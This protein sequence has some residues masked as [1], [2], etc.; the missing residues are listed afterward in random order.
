MTLQ[1]LT[2]QIVGLDEQIKAGSEALT[3]AELKKVLQSFNDLFK[4]IIEADLFN[5]YPDIIPQWNEILESALSSAWASRIAENLKDEVFYDFGLYLRDQAGQHREVTEKLIHNYLDLFRRSSFLQKIENIK[6]WE[7][8]VYEL[9]LKSNFNVNALFRQ[10]VRDYS[11]K[12]LFRLLSPS[13][14]RDYNWIQIKDLVER[15]AYGLAR[16]A[17][18]GGKKP[19]KIAFLME[20]SL[21][22]AVADLACLTSGL[23]NIMMPANSVPQQIEFILKQT[24]VRIIL[25]FNDKQLAKI[26]AIKKNLPYLK[27]VVLVRGSSIEEWVITLDEMLNTGIDFPEKTLHNMQQSVQMDDLATIMYTSGT[28]GE[29]KG[30]MFSYMN[31]VYKRFCRAMALPKISDK[32]RY[33]AYLPLFHT[34]GRY[35]ELMGA[36]FWGAE[37]AFMENPALATMIDN[38]KRVKPTIFISIPKKWQQLYEYVSSR[39]DIELAEDAAIKKEVKKATGG[40]LKWGLSAAGYL[41]PDI[42]K[43]FQRYGI[44]LMSGFGMTEATGGITMTYPG[45]YV[46][47]SLGRPLP[48]IE[49]KLSDEGEMMIRGP[50]V[51]MGYYGV[52][53]QKMV[54]VDGWLPTGDI[55]RRDKNGYYEIIDR[56][57]EI[58]KNIK[59][60]TIAPQRIENMFRDFEYVEQVF[61]VGDHQPF[62]TVLIYPAYDAGPMLKKMNEEERQNYFSSLVVTVNKFLAPFE[63]IVDFRIIDRPF[64]AEKGELTPKNTYKRRVIEK[65]FADIIDNMYTKPHVS[66]YYD[67]ME[68][69]IPNW[70]LREKG[71]LIN[72]LSFNRNGL[73]IAKYEQK[74]MLKAT[75]KDNNQYRIGNYYYFIDK[76]YI[77]FQVILANPYYWLGNQELMDFAGKAIFQ[78]FRVDEPDEKIR[79]ASIVKAERVKKADLEELHK[80]VEGDEHSL[81][82]LNLAVRFLQSPKED[83]ALIGVNYLEK[84]LSDDNFP[85]K[86]LGMEILAQPGYNRKLPVRRALFRLAHKIADEAQFERYLSVY[87][88]QSAD[89]LNDELI[90]AIGRS[91]RGEELVNCVHSVLKREL[92]RISKKTALEK[93][94]IPSLLNM[95]AAYGVH[96]P[97]KYKRVRQLLVRYQL[98]KDYRGLSKTASEARYKLLNGFREWLGPNQAVSVDVETGQEYRWQDVVIFDERIP[99]A[100]RT[101]ILAALSNTS[102][103]REAIFLFSGGNMV[104]LYDI[105]LAGVWI[106]IIDDE[107][108]KTVYRLSVQTRFQGAYDIALNLSRKPPSQEILDEINWLIHSG[109]PAKGLRLLEDFG[110]YWREYNLW[111]EEYIPGDK[112][113]KVLQRTLRRNTEEARQRIYHL[114]PFFIWTAVSAHVSFWKRAGYKLELQDKSI[115]NMVIAPHDYQTGL[116]IISIASRVPSKGLTELLI[117]FYHQ[118]ILETEQQYPFL[119]RNG[120]CNNMF[121]G[122]LDSEGEE[123]GVALLHKVVRELNGLSDEVSSRMRRHLQIFLGRIQ[124]YGF[125]PKK[126]YFA[127]KRFHRWFSINTEASLS[128]QARTLNELYDTYQLQELEKKHPETR[129]RFYLDT[130][131]Q[132]SAPEFYQAL[133]GVSQKQR[134]KKLSHE[135]TLALISQMQKSFDLSEKEKFF[136]S[137]LSYPHLKPTDSAVL[138]STQSDGAAIADVVVRLEDYDGI[139]YLVRKPISPK[140]IS[141]LHKLFLDADLPVSFRP[142]HRFMVAVS[143]REHII[144]GLFYTYIDSETVYMEKIVVSRQF[145]RKGISEGLMNEF[146][147][148]LRDARIRFVTTGFFRPEYFYRF[149]FKVEKKYAGLVKDLGK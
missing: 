59:G 130:V 12:T 123:K 100:D 77:D 127:V 48:G 125:I 115:H 122:V 10:R 106:S 134:R 149:G 19:A 46:E 83:E 79:F 68:V 110:G 45:Q 62:N 107:A 37:Y 144:G 2:Q 140:E 44:E 92:S 29:P 98:R 114:W 4:D 42:F 136:L 49:V 94:C 88:A 103:L 21:E 108:D 67:D 133:L 116:R 85:Y 96:H 39:V 9:I 70:F 105:P 75:N 146:F 118:F 6:Q 40:K 18:D 113:S 25:V 93:T 121:S 126:L 81:F 1:Q 97:T 35:L 124:E 87:V 91:A 117:D 72:D 16:L 86:N 102:M 128:A 78:W 71:C 143:E 74:L 109:A 11:Q 132:D 101:H 32:D 52:P 138:V 69:R 139:P 7:Q 104:R 51:M 8:L 55:M 56:K 47:N 111:T 24:K 99:E 33:L 36:V 137:R 60:E 57:K 26:K 41:E 131:F 76:P 28:T 141:R 53:D 80:M 50:Y 65:N 31:I 43:F 147:N 145:R 119:K 64:S 89:L 148:R 82:G 5:A 14:E 34:F 58:Y 73:Y 27:T 142:E 95:L 120:I 84:V 22:M 13:G 61:L 3:T 112:I 17:L 15:Y 38:M 129:T 30:I 63:R 54:F 90:E 135:E 66:L 20:N 23:V